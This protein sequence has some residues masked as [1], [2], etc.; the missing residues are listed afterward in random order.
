MEQSNSEA[1]RTSSKRHIKMWV[2]DAVAMSNVHK[3]ALATT[4]RD[5]Y[6]YDMSTPIYTPQFRLCGKLY[7]HCGVLFIICSFVLVM[8]KF[9]YYN[10]IITNFYLDCSSCRCCTLSRLLLQQESELLKNYWL[11]I[12]F[13]VKYSPQ[14]YYESDILSVSS[15]SERKTEAKTGKVSFVFFLS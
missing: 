7:S 12:N 5:V 6:F 9:I 8:Y 10:I 3:M 4:N 11:S 15:L 1:D 13:L 2:T 14:K